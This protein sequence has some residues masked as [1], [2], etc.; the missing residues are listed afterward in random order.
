[1][2]DERDSGGAIQVRLGQGTSTRK[3]PVANGEVTRRDPVNRSVPISIPIDDLHDITSGPSGIG[4][5]WDALFQVQGVRHGERHGT[6]LTPSYAARR[7]YP[8]KDDDD[9]RAHCCDLRLDGP[10]GP[11][12]DAHHRNDRRHADDNPEHRETGAQPISSQD[13]QRGQNRKPHKRRH[14]ALTS[15]DG[16]SRNR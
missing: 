9:V 11:L 10:L 15:H 8:G 16:S 13:P 3:G 1:M 14:L 5:Q 4:Q 6:P 12:A 2:S 7:S